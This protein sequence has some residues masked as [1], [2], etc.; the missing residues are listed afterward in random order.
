MRKFI[1]LLIPLA[2]AATVAAHAQAP[3][4]MPGDGPDSPPP[5]R[6]VETSLTG[7][8]A[9]V[10]DKPA[11]KADSGTI[12]LVFPDFFRYAYFQGYK[13]GVSIKAKGFLVTLPAPPQDATVQSSQ[14]VQSKFDAKELTIGAQTYIIVA[15]PPRHW[16]MD[17]RGPSR[18]KMGPPSFGPTSELAVPESSEEAFLGSDD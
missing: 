16:P 6:P 4:P 2:L 8:L 9:F 13:A 5:L 10:D 15:G 1:Q 3:A 11:I 7:V 12:L 18:D 14:A 17:R